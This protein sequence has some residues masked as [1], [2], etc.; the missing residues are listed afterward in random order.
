MKWK[1]RKEIKL[2][3]KKYGYKYPIW[4]WPWGPYYVRMVDG[5]E[6]WM[7]RRSKNKVKNNIAKYAEK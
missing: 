7:W 4:T 1:P 3:Y 6:S 2:Y 5:I